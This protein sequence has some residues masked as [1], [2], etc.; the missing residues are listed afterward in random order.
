MPLNSLVKVRRFKNLVV[1][2]LENSFVKVRTFIFQRIAP[3]K[4]Y[5][6]K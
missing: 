5:Q 4:F 1:D 2:V 3:Q 6:R